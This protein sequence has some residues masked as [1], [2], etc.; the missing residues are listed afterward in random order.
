MGKGYMPNVKQESCFEV[1]LEVMDVRK[2]KKK[3][4]KTF[5]CDSYM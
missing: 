1:E 5:T 4:K 3:E 2:K